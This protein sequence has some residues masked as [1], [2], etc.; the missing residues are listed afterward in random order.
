MIN[1]DDLIYWC[2]YCLLYAFAIAC[3]GGVGFL[4]YVLTCV[5]IELIQKQ[6]QA[7]KL[8]TRYIGWLRYSRRY[9]KRAASIERPKPKRRR[10][11]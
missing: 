3:S 2:G 9:N 10:L 1:H 6:A 7:V 5:V 11:K 8:T 4:L